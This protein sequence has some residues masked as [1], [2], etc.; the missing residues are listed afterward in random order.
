[1]PPAVRRIG[2]F[3]AYWALGVCA[4]AALA[5]IIRLVV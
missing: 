1:M 4:L 2:W 3:V 5:L